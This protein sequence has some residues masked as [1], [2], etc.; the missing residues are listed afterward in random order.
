MTV[1]RY[2]SVY[3]RSV[4][5]VWMNVVHFRSA[6][7]GVCILPRLDLLIAYYFMDQS[8]WRYDVLTDDVGFGL[9][10]LR[11]FSGFLSLLLLLTP[12]MLDEV[13]KI[14]P[15]KSDHY[16]YCRLQRFFVCKKSRIRFETVT[17]IDR[18]TL[19]G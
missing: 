2:I 12:C 1:F 6:N 13:G 9:C 7:A 5:E 14:S 16:T 3:V 18:S 11:L 10:M 4:C 8:A 19:D 15:D 17:W